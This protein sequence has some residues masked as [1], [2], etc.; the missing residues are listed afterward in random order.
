MVRSTTNQ[1]Y[2]RGKDKATPNNITQKH[3]RDGNAGLEAHV[4][5]LKRTNGIGLCSLE[6]ESEQ[7]EEENTINSCQGQEDIGHNFGNMPQHGGRDNSLDDEEHDTEH[8]VENIERAS[9]RRRAPASSGGK[10]KKHGAPIPRVEETM[11]I[12]VDLK[13]EQLKSKKHASEEEKQYSIPRCFEVVHF[14]DDLSDEIKV[15][16]S[17]VFKDAVNREIFLCYKDRL[18]GLWLKKVVTKLG[19]SN[20]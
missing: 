1:V 2:L 11:S 7:H 20:A 6:V 14:M 3:P 4:D 17:D 13:R 15:M 18:R 12:F 8:Q 16:A 9:A 10:S 5:T 19:H